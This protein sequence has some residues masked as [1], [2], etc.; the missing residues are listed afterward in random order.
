MFLQAWGH[1]GG[2]A[3]DGVRPAN[4]AS[5]VAHAGS[6]GPAAVALPAYLL[7]PPGRR[8]RPRAVPAARHGGP[9]GARAL[10]LPGEQT[11]ADTCIASPLCI[12]FTLHHE[13]VNNIHYAIL[14]IKRGFESEIK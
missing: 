7:L 11:A 13:T 6:A 3:V 10:P 12:S 14:F 1:V 2:P 5:S 9:L 4:V 8:L